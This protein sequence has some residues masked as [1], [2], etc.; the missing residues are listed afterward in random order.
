MI[1]LDTD[2]LIDTALDR[3]PHSQPAS[4]LLDRIEYGAESAFIAWHSISNFYY[5]VAPVSGGAS[6]RYFIVELTGFVSVATTNMEA[7]RYAAGLPMS[8]FEDA[9]QVAAAR[10]CG[11]R[12]IVTRNVRDYQRSPIPAVD[13]RE[14]IRQLF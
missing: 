8:D 4:D 5:I 3:S 7:I 10:A 1:L 13:P 9:M 2:V 12:H 14:A 6:A 11:A